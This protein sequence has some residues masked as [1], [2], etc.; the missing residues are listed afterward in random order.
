MTKQE[1]INAWLQVFPKSMGT[2]RSLL[3]DE[4]EF[5]FAGYLIA[6]KNEAINNIIDNDA[7]K[8]TVWF[9]DEGTAKES[10]LHV[11]IKPESSFLVYSSASMR[12]KTI[13]NVTHEKL[14]KRF[15]DIKNWLQ[16]N[17]NNFHDNHSVLIN[18]K[19]F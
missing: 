6:N 18:S 8:Y 3:S 9:D 4:N 12:K 5:C 14:I 19:I 11:L 1:V 15:T 2:A 7:F 17:K 10:M 13:K 16:D